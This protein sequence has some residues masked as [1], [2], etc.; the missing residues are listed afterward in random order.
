MSEK[1]D[2]G[3]EGGTYRAKERKQ[4]RRSTVV[5]DQFFKLSEMSKFLDLEDQREN[6]R[7]QKEDEQNREGMMTFFIDIFKFFSNVVDPDPQDPYHMFL[8]LPGSDTSLFFTDPH[9][10]PDPSI[11][12]QKK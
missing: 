11:H 2:D 3:E 1:E 10:D 8:G 4:S 6:K 5:D 9:L 7:R 12:K